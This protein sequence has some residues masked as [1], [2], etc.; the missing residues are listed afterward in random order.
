MEKEIASFGKERD[1]HLKAAKAKLTGAKA[2]AET[3]KKALKGKQAALTEALAQKDAAAGETEALRQQLQ[4]A[5]QGIEGQ[6][7]RAVICRS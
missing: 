1:K 4:T 3:A 5:E 6:P 2:G 7:P